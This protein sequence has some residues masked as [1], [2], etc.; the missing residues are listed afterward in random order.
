MFSLSFALRYRQGYHPDMIS[1]DIIPICLAG[2]LFPSFIKAD[3]IE[4]KGSEALFSLTHTPLL[5]GPPDAP[6]AIEAHHIPLKVPTTNC[7]DAELGS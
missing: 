1:K 4:F 2:F 3:R 7:A 6:S 5:F